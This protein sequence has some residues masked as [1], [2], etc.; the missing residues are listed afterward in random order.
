MQAI[1]VKM[2][3]NLNPLFHRLVLLLILDY[4]NSE[5]SCFQQE[6]KPEVLKGH[7]NPIFPLQGIVVVGCYKKKELKPIGYCF[8]SIAS[9]A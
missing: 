2:G 3:L 9:V 1:F 5:P 4:N 7:I 6:K 8:R